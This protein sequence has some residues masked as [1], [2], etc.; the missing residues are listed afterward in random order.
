MV[1]IKQRVYYDRGRSPFKESNEDTGK[2]RRVDKTKRKFRVGI[3][4]RDRGPRKT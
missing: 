3:K 2:L 1:T 4:D